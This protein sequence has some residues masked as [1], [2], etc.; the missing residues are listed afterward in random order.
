MFTPRA[1]IAVVLAGVVGTLANSVIVAALAPAPFVDLATGW[2]R[3]A[4]AIVVAL[5]LPVI[6]GWKGGAPG[7]IV[8]IAALTIIPSILAK[9]AFAVGAPWPFVLGV[10]AVYAV[11]ALIVYVLVVRTTPRGV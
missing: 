4:V 1:L 9:T 8:S 5:L 10:N 2:G 7:W 11:A 3:Y 6:L